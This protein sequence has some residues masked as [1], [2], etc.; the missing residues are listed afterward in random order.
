MSD[1]KAMEQVRK[2]RSEKPQQTETPATAEPASRSP[3]DEELIKHSDELL[4]AIDDLLEENAEA[5]VANYIQAGG[6]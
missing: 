6:Q 5:F 2:S 1:N 3:E 4:D